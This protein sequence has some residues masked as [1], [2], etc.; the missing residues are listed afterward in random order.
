MIILIAG[1]ADSGKSSY[2]E[3]I[4]QELDGTPKIYL[5]TAEIIDDEMHERVKRHKLMRRG[6]G[7]VTVER[8]R[9]LAGVSI[10]EGACVLIESLT[11]WTA[12]E[13]FGGDVNTIL[14][15]FMSITQRAKHTVIVADDIFSDG[16]T[17]DELTEKYM[18]TLGELLVKIAAVSDRVIECFAGLP[19]IYN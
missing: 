15:D 13:M 5:A 8:P 1:T 17:Y 9:N 11:T 19:V 10:P 14:H 4:F 2:A 12:N 18:R 3:K 6:K 7:F 16:V